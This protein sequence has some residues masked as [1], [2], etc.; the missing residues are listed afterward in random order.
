M[1][2]SMSSGRTLPCSRKKLLVIAKNTLAVII[3]FLVQFTVKKID[4][5]YCD[6]FEEEINTTA[7][8]KTDDALKNEASAQ[9]ALVKTK[10]KANHKWGMLLKTYLQRAF[11]KKGIEVE[12]FP[13]GF[14]DLRTDEAGMIDT[15]PQVIELAKKYKTTL[16][17]KGMDA[18]F[19]EQG[20]NL[21][22]ELDELSKA[23]KKLESDHKAYREERHLAHLALY[24]KINYI[25]SVGR[26]IFAEDP[27][28]LK[29]F[30]SPWATG[31]DDGKDNETPAAGANT[32]PAAG[33][34]K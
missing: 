25:N 24:D 11:G 19:I 2:E 22:K 14:E 21:L 34:T 3:Q 6:T 10:C 27:V 32:P 5:Q 16:Q 17:A 31:K 9:N 13:N 8:L 20:I 15:M 18:N 30:D 4:Q 1:E 23:D 28:N 12:E 33:G 26:E 29:Y 7:K